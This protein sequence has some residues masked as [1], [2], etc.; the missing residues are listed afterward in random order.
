M[1]MFFGTLARIV[2]VL[3]G[4]GCA[5]LGCLWA[6]TVGLLIIAVIIA[7]IVVIVPGVLAYVLWSAADG[8]SPEDAT[9]KMFAALDL[10]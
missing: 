2:A 10:Q 5:A 3:L 8:T 1:N 7:L 4:A 9:R 6:V